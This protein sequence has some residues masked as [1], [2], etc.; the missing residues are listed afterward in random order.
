MLLQTR[1]SQA[2]LSF[3]TTILF[4]KAQLHRHVTCENSNLRVQQ[5]VEGDDIMGYFNSIATNSI[6]KTVK[7][8]TLVS[9]VS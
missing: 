5:M 6:T 7:E 1:W 2:T 8:T 9:C 3:I 4:V